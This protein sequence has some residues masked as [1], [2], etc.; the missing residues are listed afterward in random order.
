MIQHKEWIDMLLFGER[1]TL[2]SGSQVEDNLFVEIMVCKE[3]EEKAKKEE[4]ETKL[5][6]QS[7]M[8]MFLTLI[9][10]VHVNRITVQLKEKIKKRMHARTWT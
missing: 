5:S 7:I 4:E 3:V 9:L 1:S 2:V 8:N 6:L 10:S